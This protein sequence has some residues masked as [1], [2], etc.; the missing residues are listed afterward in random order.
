MY[1]VDLTTG[2]LTIGSGTLGFNDFAFTAGGGFGPG[3]YTLFQTTQLISGT[4]DGGNL[5]GTVGGFGATLAFAGGGTDLVLQVVPE[6][7]SLAMLLFGAMAM[8]F[9]GVR[10]RSMRLQ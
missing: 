5:S 6:P 1:L 8:W 4:L 2:T 3:T 10:K 7:G 9:V